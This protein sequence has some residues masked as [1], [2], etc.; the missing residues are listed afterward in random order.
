[1]IRILVYIPCSAIFEIAEEP[2]FTAPATRHQ[3]L[4]HDVDASCQ[5]FMRP[6]SSWHASWFLGTGPPIVEIQYQY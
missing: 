4:E 6:M 5:H 3:Q 2:V 1:M